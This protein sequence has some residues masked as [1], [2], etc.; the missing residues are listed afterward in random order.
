MVDAMALLSAAKRLLLAAAVGENPRN[1]NTGT[2]IIPPPRPIIEPNIPAANP[3]AISHNWSIIV[4]AN[5]R[6][7]L[8]IIRL[9]ENN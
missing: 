8:Y 7:L 3:R 2:T 4:I 6:I 9:L 1:V 5:Q